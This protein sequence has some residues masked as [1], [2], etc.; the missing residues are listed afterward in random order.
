MIRRLQFLLPLGAGFGLQQAAALVPARVEALYSTRI[1]PE[2]AALLVK[3]TGWLPFALADALAFAGAMVALGVLIHCIRAVRVDPRR[4]WRAAIRFLLLAA[5]LVYLVFLLV[6]GLNYRREPLASS[7]GLDTRPAPLEE[8]ARLAEELTV[9]ASALR[10][11]RAEDAGVFRLG[12]GVDGALERATQGFGASLPALPRGAR[13]KGSLLSPLLARLG[14]SGIFIPF[15]GEPLVDTLLPDSEVPFSASHELAHLQGW[16]RE[17]EASFVAFEA[18]RA[19]PDPDFRYSGVLVAS[20]HAVA[21]LAARDRDAATRL[22]AT[23]AP[24]VAR[25]VAAIRAWRLRYEG[26]LSRFGD[27]VN[28]TYLKAQGDPRGL[29]SY[30]RMVDLLLAARRAGRLARPDTMAP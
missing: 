27:R 13:P 18:C 30:G 7:L 24:A 14:I 11:D 22:A 10:T 12:G 5:G 6:W 4:A 29:H 15:T 1:Y 20:L 3:A 19:H 8:L 28:D 2:V 21:A 16:A 23:R 25:D 17:D 26:A 9:D